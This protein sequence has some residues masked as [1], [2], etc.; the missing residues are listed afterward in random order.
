ML[1]VKKK[2]GDCL[3]IEYGSLKEMQLSWPWPCSYPSEFLKSKYIM[4]KRQL[5]PGLGQERY[6]LQV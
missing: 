3:S 4:S 2:Q 5:F 6:I 1:K